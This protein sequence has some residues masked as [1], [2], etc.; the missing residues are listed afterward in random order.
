[1]FPAD[2]KIE[3]NDITTCTMKVNLE[4][5]KYTRR[6]EWKNENVIKK[7]KELPTQRYYKY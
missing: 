5:S 3:Y 7:Y 1:M 2:N 6:R 4:S